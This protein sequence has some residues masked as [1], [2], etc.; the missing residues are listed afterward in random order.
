MSEFI[1]DD[2]ITTLTWAQYKQKGDHL[3][4]TQGYTAKQ[5][6]DLYGKP[7][8]DGVVVEIT[9]GGPNTIRQ[10]SAAAREK[11]RLN[12]QRKTGAFKNVD[13]LPT[14]IKKWGKRLTDKGLW[15]KGKSLEGFI[16]AHK[17]SQ[18]KLLSDIEALKG[19]GFIDDETG[20]SLIDDGHLIAVGKEQK[21]GHP[22]RS[23]GTHGSHFGESRV[24]ELSAV[25]QAKREAGDID[26][27][28]A[29][30]GGIITDDLDAFSQYLTDDA[31]FGPGVKPSTSSKQQIAQGANPDQVI[32]RQIEKTETSRQRQAFN[33]NLSKLDPKIADAVKVIDK[34]SG[35]TRKAD[36]AAQ[37]VT[38]VATGNPIQA[39][40]AGTTLLASEA[41]QS[42][43]A[44][45]AISKQIAKMAA[46][47]AGK[48]ALKAVPGLDVLI[49]GKEAWDYAA[50]GKFDQAGIAALS[51]AIGWIP[52]IG[53]GASAALDFTNT[54]IDISRLDIPNQ[55]KSKTKVDTDLPTNRGA[56]KS[57]IKSLS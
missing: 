51:G 43:A 36:L 24:P 30:R 46:N 12:R 40:V 35:K 33:A 3:R 14:E 57:A 1:G 53:D 39:G 29:K 49:S 18:A 15:P 16:Q 20:K 52:V 37:A 23:K 32:E 4:K 55:K 25:N 34:L 11:S 45:K 9:T 44:Q 31:G 27:L 42:P 26:F 50:Q 5:I 28:D 6:K 21:T 54:G 47:R 13:T 7:V 2:G 38:G 10:R 19:M 48:T 17:T 56:L 41:L 8:I 22:L